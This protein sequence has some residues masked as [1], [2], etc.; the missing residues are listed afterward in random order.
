MAEPTNYD[1]EN[2]LRLLPA[3]VLAAAQAGDHQAEYLVGHAYC[4]DTMEDLEFGPEY[5]DEEGV[6]WLTRAATGGHARAQYELGLV[7]DF[8]R[9]DKAEATRWLT[10]AGENGEKRA[11]GMLGEMVMGNTEHRVNKAAV[12]YWLKGVEHGDALSQY[13]LAWCYQNGQGGLASNMERAYELYRLAAE[14]GESGAQLKMG[15]ACRE[16]EFIPRDLE[17]AAR[18]F[19]MAAA[20]GEAQSAAE[21]GWMYL[22]GEYSTEGQP[23]DP[24]RA[25]RLF[26][27]AAKE[28]QPMAFWG[29][30]HLYREGL[31]V[32]KNLRR[33]LF[34]LEVADTLFE[35]DEGDLY[36]EIEKIRDTLVVQPLKQ[37]LK[38]ATA[39]MGVEFEA[40]LD[41]TFVTLSEQLS[42]HRIQIAAEKFAGELDGR[43]DKD[44]LPRWLRDKWMGWLHW[45]ETFDRAEPVL[46][47]AEAKRARKKAP[48]VTRP[49]REQYTAGRVPQEPC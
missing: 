17:A 15:W 25:L 18:W 16:G 2:P 43:L 41:Q 28:A 22:R 29:L 33:S 8:I 6:M 12:P 4:Y 47:L 30:G 3:G 49:N 36:D 11:Y 35:C 5:D 37:K 45:P 31:Y 19:E 46:T 27:Y 40:G 21:L 38:A 23:G 9:S 10:S 13:R 1:D 42:K 34:W 24:G 14:Q 44:D 32:E 39:G 26:A 7:Y 20:S 48:Q